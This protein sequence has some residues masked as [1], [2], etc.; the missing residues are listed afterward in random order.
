MPDGGEKL[1]NVILYLSAKILTKT[2][3]FN[4]ATAT[5]EKGV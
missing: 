3:A 4:N 1:R 2:S 5:R